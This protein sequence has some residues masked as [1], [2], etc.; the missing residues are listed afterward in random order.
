MF[1][2]GDLV[3]CVNTKGYIPSTHV[4]HPCAK[5]ARETHSNYHW[6][7]Q[8]F[9]FLL[10]EYNYRSFGLKKHKSSRLVKPFLLEAHVIPRGKLTPHPQCTPGIDSVD[11]D[12][13]HM[14]YR[15][16]LNMKWDNDTIKLTWTRRGAP[17]WKGR[18]DLCSW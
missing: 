13:T 14:A 3:K 15:R 2:V 11:S 1:M 5:W 18:N 17:Y 16:Y 9:L 4:N 8:Y 6:L 7:R 10:N 12:W